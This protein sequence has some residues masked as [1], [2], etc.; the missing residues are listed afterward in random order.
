MRRWKGIDEEKKTRKA[1]KANEREKKDRN[2]CDKST[3]RRDKGQ[4]RK[5]YGETVGETKMKA[6][7]QGY[8]NVENF[9]R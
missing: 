6:M 1:N 4:G 2:D 7:R 9:T 8:N 5:R 3:K